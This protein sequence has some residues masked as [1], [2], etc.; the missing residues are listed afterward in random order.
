ML[1]ACHD[2]WDDGIWDKSIGKVSVGIAAIFE[3]YSEANFAHWTPSLFVTFL[4]KLRQTIFFL[5]SHQ[6]KKT[7]FIFF[8]VI[9]ERSQ[10][11]PLL[12]YNLLPDR[13]ERRKLCIAPREQKELDEGR[14]K[15]A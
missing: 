5:R 1:A 12:I 4:L 3:M 6:K 11:Y 7:P 2:G 15:K 14:K 8:F 13:I 10:K 9:E